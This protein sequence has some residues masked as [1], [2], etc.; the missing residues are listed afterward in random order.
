[1]ERMSWHYDEWGG[2][3]LSPTN[4]R[5]LRDSTRADDA[6]EMNSSPPFF[7]FFIF[8]PKKF[9]CLKYQHMCGKYQTV[10]GCVSCT[11]HLVKRNLSDRNAYSGEE[12]EGIKKK[13]KKNN[14]KMPK[15]D[16]IL[17]FR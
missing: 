1:M 6:A 3:I 9:P 8:H 12:T 11:A 15:N 7:L 2:E 5:T 17:L 4:N 16:V 10:V 13:R 14:I